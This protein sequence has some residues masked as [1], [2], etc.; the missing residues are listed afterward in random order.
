MVTITGGPLEPDGER[1]NIQ[2]ATCFVGK[3]ALQSQFIEMKKMPNLVVKLEKF[4]EYTIC[5][6]KINQC[7]IDNTKRL[8]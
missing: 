1:S 2:K 4:K 3:Y 7:S 6:T 8:E 5:F